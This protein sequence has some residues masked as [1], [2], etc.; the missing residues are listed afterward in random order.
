MYSYRNK[1]FLFIFKRFKIIEI[2][3]LFTNFLWMILV[4][5]WLNVTVKSLQKSVFQ[6]PYA[7]GSKRSAKPENKCTV[8]YKKQ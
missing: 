8:L 1:L 2:I 6:N 5:E 7:G 3:M 4:T